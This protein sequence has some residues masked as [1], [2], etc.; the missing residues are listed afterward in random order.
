MTA[1][2]QDAIRYR[3]LRA[4]SQSVV[5][6]FKAHPDHKPGQYYD[7]ETRPWFGCGVI[8][9][10]PGEELDKICDERVGGA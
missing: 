8:L 9:C 10:L 1:D 6:W 5:D 3:A 7:G 2:T 4:Y